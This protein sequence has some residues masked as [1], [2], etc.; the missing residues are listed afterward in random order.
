MDTRAYLQLENGDVKHIPPS[1][2]VVSSPSA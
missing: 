1:Y 2:A